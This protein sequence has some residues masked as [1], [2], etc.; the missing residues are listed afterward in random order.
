MVGGGLSGLVAAYELSRTP[1]LRE[2]FEVT[3]YERTWRLGGKLA[4]GRD[5]ERGERNEEHGLHVWFGFYN[6]TFALADEVYRRWRAPAGCPLQTPL[7]FLQAHHVAMFAEPHGAAHR[8]HQLHLPRT[9][10]APLGGRARLD[11]LQGLVGAVDLL[12]AATANLLGVAGWPRGGPRHPGPLWL[13]RWHTGL[14]RRLA[15]VLR[16]SD[17]ARRQ[18]AGTAL[19]RALAGLHRLVHRLQRRLPRTSRL[20]QPTATL[21]CSVAFV[22]GLL[23]EDDGILL[24]GDLDRISD[25]ELHDWLAQRGASADSV[26]HSTV[27]QG[28]Y[29][30]FFQFAGGDRDRRSFEAGTAARIVLRGLF[31][32]HG[33][34]AWLLQTGMGE[35]FIS[36]LYEVLRDQ[37]VRFA[38]FHRFD[39]LEL[40]DDRVV[41]LRFTREGRLLGERYE[42]LRTVAGQRC[43]GV[44]PDRSQVAPCAEPVVVRDLDDVVMALPLGVLAPDAGG[45]SVVEPWFDRVPAARR[46]A[47]AINLQASVSAQ[48][49]LD[50]PLDGFASRASVVCW[51]RPYSV[52]CD[53]SPVLQHER[54]GPDGPVCSVYLC[55]VDRL[56]G[57][58][59][60]ADE[61]ARE[62]LAQQL[63]REGGLLHEGGFDFDALHDPQGRS[64]PERLR[65]QHVRFNVAPT[66]LCDGAVPGTARL[67]L[68]AHESGLHNLA[69]A[70]TWT[71]TGLNTTCVEAAVMSGMAA[72]RAL[73][74]CGRGIVG[75][76]LLA[77]PARKGL[78]PS[79][80]AWTS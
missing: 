41:A 24:D 1:E 33:A 53:M 42:P 77:R 51:S 29:D 11:P 36:P 18:R 30:A 16:H 3:V 62:R 74:G 60:Q 76:D 43:W 10:G 71:R 9:G 75:E 78:L 63:I 4:S 22:R 48:L 54:W 58:A 52:F 12:R 2:R 45:R 55:G 46:A 57:P 61:V 32:Y 5:P 23:H 44:R 17:P 8:L 13:R 79:A 15:A 59:A 39:G 27:L 19:E 56:E 14:G 40:E 47:E 20:W 64:G 80:L 34:V 26:A 68:E 31:G 6:N 73:G 49:W 67:R 69:I 72:A 28:Q 35:A 50:R 38:F 25:R 37:G 7:D 65:A 70:S 66:D 21:D